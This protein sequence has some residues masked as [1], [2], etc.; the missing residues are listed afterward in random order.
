MNLKKT[1]AVAVAAC[2]IAAT[3]ALSQPA[4]SFITFGG[5]DWAWASPCTG[6][7]GCGGNVL[8]VNPGGQWRYA[9]AAEWASHPVYNDFVDPFGN[10]NGAQNGVR[11]RCA[12]AYFGS[13]Y[14]HCDDINFI[15]GLVGSGPG[16]GSGVGYEE[17][18][19]VRGQAVPEPASLALMG[20]GL[21]GLFGVARRRKL[22]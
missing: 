8:G 5:L 22:A 3:P 4:N 11:I 13:G 15:Q 7:G 16:I 17:T 21:V 10:S 18:L 20:T 19:V 2:A 6:I 12:S 1:I 9:T 14:S